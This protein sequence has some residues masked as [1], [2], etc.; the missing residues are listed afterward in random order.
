MLESRGESCTGPFGGLLAVCAA[1]LLTPFRDFTQKHRNFSL[2]NLLI[3]VLFL[4][5]DSNLMLAGDSPPRSALGGALG[6]FFFCQ[7]SEASRFG[8]DLAQSGRKDN[9]TR[10]DNEHKA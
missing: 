8:C 5:P 2:Q 9:L 7:T 10:A 4:F 1:L 6:A 3:F